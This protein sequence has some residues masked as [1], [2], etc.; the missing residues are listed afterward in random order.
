MRPISKQLTKEI[1]IPGLFWG[2]ALAV[3]LA[4]LIGNAAM[5][6]VLILQNGT[7]IEGEVI[8][9]TPDGVLFKGKIAGIWGEVFFERARVERLKREPG[10]Q[11]VEAQGLGETVQKQP[12]RA[13]E[14]SKPRPSKRG[15]D[16]EQGE[17]SLESAPAADTAIGDIVSKAESVR[18]RVEPELVAMFD[19]WPLNVLECK[20]TDPIRALDEKP[21]ADQISLVIK[22]DVFVDSEK[23][24][25]WATAAIDR[26]D[27]L[28]LPSS[29]AAWSA[30]N[31]PRLADGDVTDPEE[32]MESYLPFLSDAV[33]KQPLYLLRGA[34]FHTKAKLSRQQA[35]QERVWFPEGVIYD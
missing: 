4:L 15:S 30:K 20:V 27:Q 31:F 25:N 33:R 7:I 11:G 3:S 16:S 1:Q 24:K 34:V 18:A 21:A 9:E 32:L 22:V 8:S 10:D 35:F 29:R 23:W 14:A 17:V 6:D 2:S 26:L 5:A 19:G 12:P 13:P 28:D